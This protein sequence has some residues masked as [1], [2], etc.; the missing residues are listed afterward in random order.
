MIK[1][2]Y[3]ILRAVKCTE[4]IL[5]ERYA[6]RIKATPEELKEKYLKLETPERKIRAKEYLER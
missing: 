6:K 2:K 1:V 4:G 3:L 5:M